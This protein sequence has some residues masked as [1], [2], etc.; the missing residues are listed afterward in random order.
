MT[1]ERDHVLLVLVKS[2]D[3]Q[4]TPSRKKLRVEPIGYEHKMKSECGY[5]TVIADLQCF[6]V[7]EIN[8]QTFSKFSTFSKRSICKKTSECVHKISG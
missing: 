5:Q 1:S 3:F 7:F 8:W 2:E 6:E 4:E